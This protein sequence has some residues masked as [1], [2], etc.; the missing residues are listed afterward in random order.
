VTKRRTSKRAIA[1]ARRHRRAQRWLVLAVAGVVLLG[2]LGAWLVSQSSASPKPDPQA[3]SIARTFPQWL[4][5]APAKAQ[6][7]YTQAIKHRDE[8]GYIPCY[9][10]CEKIEHVS[11]ADCHVDDFA[12]DG[13]IS[14]DRHAVG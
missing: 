7:S 8:L 5:S 1:R 11:V 3:T 13:S 9:C 10:G 2:G 14:Y 12:A 6:R 4:V